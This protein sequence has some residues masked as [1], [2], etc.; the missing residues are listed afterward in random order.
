MGKPAILL[1]TVNTGTSWTRLILSSR[2][3]GSPILVA[4]LSP[5]TAQLV[6]D[7]GAIYS[8]SNSATT[9]QAS[10]LESLS[11]TLNRTISSG[12]RGHLFRRLS[13]LSQSL[14]I[15]PI[16]IC[17]YSWQLLSN[18]VAR[19]ILVATTQPACR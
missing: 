1:H 19:V 15:G 5:R 3:P 16:C 17:L 14:I 6:T 18:L 13:L 11:S 12:I 2:L 4:A 8:T 7:Q 10:V 9:W